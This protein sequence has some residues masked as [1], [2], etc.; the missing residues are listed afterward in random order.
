MSILALPLQVC[1][2]SSRVGTFSPANCGPTRL[3]R[4]TARSSSA[5]A[6]QIF[7]GEPAT[8]MRSLS[9]TTITTPSFDSWTSI[10]T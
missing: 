5:V 4:S 3:P 10:S 9:C 6:S 7:R 8:F 1:R 2:A